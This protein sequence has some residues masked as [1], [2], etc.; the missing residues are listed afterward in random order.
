LNISV[1]TKS[2]GALFTNHAFIGA[3]PW[4]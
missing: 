2:V 4:M 1:E 3:Q